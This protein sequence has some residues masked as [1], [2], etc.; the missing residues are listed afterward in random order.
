MKEEKPQKPTL[1][2]KKIVYKKIEV[3]LR[4]TDKK[5]KDRVT[6]ILKKRNERK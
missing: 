3:W 5:E 4:N 6:E 1:E 2:Q